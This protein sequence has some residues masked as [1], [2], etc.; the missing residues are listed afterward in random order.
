MKQIPNGEAN[1]H[2]K[3]NDCKTRKGENR[4]QKYEGKK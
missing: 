3:K 1:K 4:R 2:K